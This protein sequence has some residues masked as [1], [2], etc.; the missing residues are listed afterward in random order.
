MDSGTVV[1]WLVGPGQRVFRG[2][3]VAVVDTDK[4]AI[5]VECF[6]SGVVQQLLVKPGERVAVGTPLAMIGAPALTE[7]PMP[8]ERPPQPPPGPERP[9]IPSPPPAPPPEPTPPLEPPAP[10][11]PERPPGPEPLPEP[12]RPPMSPAP[13]FEAA[14]APPPRQPAVLSPLV[15]KLAATIGVDLGTVRGTGSGGVITRADVEH[16]AAAHR[17]GALAAPRVRISPFARR[18]A[19]ERGVGLRGLRGTAADGSVRARDVPAASQTV[20]DSRHDAGM[21]AMRRAT[22]ALMAR[23]KREI[24][25]YYL[26]ASIGL[27][28][29]QEWLR[30]R[31]HSAPI[32]DRV[33]PAAL[34]LR[35]TVL[36]AAAAPDLN[37]HWIDEQ[38][39][40][41]TAVHLGVAVSLRGGGLIAPVIH[42]AGQLSLDE[43]MQ[44]LRGL[45][46]RAR[47]GRLRSSEVAGATITV[48]NLG[49]LGAES[50]FGVIYPPQVALVGFGA[51]CERPWV[52]DG[53]LTVA[54]VVTATLSADHRASDGAIGARLL[55]AID[56]ALQR[57]ED[58]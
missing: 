55:H 8:P 36:A 2:D 47:A 1:E 28:R 20:R 14:R 51:V 30:E 31:N 24:P 44:R 48:T 29:A 32:T 12:M 37:G 18:L 6:E 40:P 49:D 42:D 54:P 34:L 10:P 22:A 39:R 56:R 21:A 43:L 17:D 9:P 53:A 3:V 5:D 13:T 25:H 4:A 23:A 50:V 16:A 19:A 46:E 52:A 35:A 27:Q 45:V 41:A 58:L 38:L 7:P 26:S 57:P 11:E 15:R 33:V